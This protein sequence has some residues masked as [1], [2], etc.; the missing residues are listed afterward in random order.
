MTKDDRRFA[1]H[2]FGEFSTII[3]SHH[4]YLLHNNEILMVLR[5]VLVGLCGRFDRNAVSARVLRNFNE[6][7]EGHIAPKKALQLKK[8]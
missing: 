3:P 1:C 8:K 2:I 6:I 7:Y 5:R 4:R